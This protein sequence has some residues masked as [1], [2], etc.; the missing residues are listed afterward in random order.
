M[1]KFAGT[2]VR[3]I[4]KLMAVLGLLCVALPAWAQG[5]WTDIPCADSFLELKPALKCFRHST[6]RGPGDP[7]GAVGSLHVTEGSVGGVTISVLLSWPVGDGTF[8]KGYTTD[9]ALRAIKNHDKFTRE[10]ASNWGELR[11][12]GNV[13]Y[14]T[15]RADSRAC[16]GFDDAGP[17]FEYGYAWR[18]IGYACVSALDSPEAFVKAVLGALRVG[19]PGSIKSALGEDVR[20]LAW[21]AS[22]S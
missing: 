12:F 22:N 2:G 9:A 14:T 17:L 15:F 21:S 7:V 5:S 19:P 6:S 16:V 1:L 11:G 3:L 8:I 20:P 10:R 4:K 13:T 18:I